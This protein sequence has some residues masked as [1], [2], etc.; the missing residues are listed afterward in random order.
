ME[1]QNGNKFYPN[2]T[3]CVP[4]LHVDVKGTCANLTSV[5]AL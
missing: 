1:T 3:E 2:D 4:T 5:M